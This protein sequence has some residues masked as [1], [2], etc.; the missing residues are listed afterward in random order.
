[1][2]DPPLVFCDYLRWVAS[3]LAAGVLVLALG[4]AEDG[5]SQEPERPVWDGNYMLAGAGAT[6]A[7]GLAA[8][9]LRARTGRCDEDDISSCG[10]NMVGAHI[11]FGPIAAVFN[12]TSIGLAAGGGTLRRR[13][14]DWQVATGKA[15]P[16]NTRAMRTTGGMLLGVG[17]AGSIVAW[18]FVGAPSENEG[19]VAQ[20]A[21]LQASAMLASAGAGLLAYGVTPRPKRRQRRKHSFHLAPMLSSN[22]G[23][24]FGGRF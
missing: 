18:S 17:L 11:F 22:L 1:L 20:I 16:R 7:L 3:L 13:Y 4:G 21:G 15:R 14:D 8:N 19:F 9:V 5:A 6:S 12:L 23:L 10:S 24:S 2:L